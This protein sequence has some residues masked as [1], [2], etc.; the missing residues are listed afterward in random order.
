MILASKSLHQ[1]NAQAKMKM[2]V[3]VD[4]ADAELGPDR[5]CFTT[6]IDR[7]IVPFAPPVRIAGRSYMRSVS[8]DRKITATASAGLTS[9]SVIRQN[10]CHALAPSTFA[11][12]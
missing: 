8:S 1:P 10:R 11:D 2:K 4:S 6:R 3:I 12:S 5:I 7:V 9:G